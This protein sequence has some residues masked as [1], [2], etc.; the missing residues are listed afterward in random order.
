VRHRWL[1]P[2]YPLTMVPLMAIGIQSTGGTAIAWLFALATL[3][4]LWRTFLSNRP[5]ALAAGALAYAA[6]APGQI[7]FYSVYPLSMLTFFTVLHLWFLHRERWVAAG[8]AGAG[9]A[10]TYPTGV[11]L[12]AV[13]ALWLAIERNAGVLERLRRIALTSGLTLVGALAVVLVQ[14]IQTGAW[15]AY[16]KVQA[17]Y[18]HVLQ[19]P[20]KRNWEEVRS[21]FDS[22]LLTIYQAP[23][24]QTA[25]VTLVMTACLGV[26][27]WEF[28]R[29]GLTRLDALMGIWAVAFWAF[30]LAQGNV[31]LYR[32]QATLLP[33]AVLAR[34]PGP[35]VYLMAG[36]AAWLTIPMTTL[37]LLT[38]LV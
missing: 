20:L 1:V 35:A 18:G 8:L 19:E 31:A 3:V 7:F 22:S 36:A 23:A 17:K 15:D 38:K 13:S 6:F 25:F 10:M 32:S 24:V 5:L 4:A 37:F 28:L 2:L 9:A 33:L 11:L 14:L 30:P 16:F 26:L 29:R 21:A 27:G 34:L 12:V